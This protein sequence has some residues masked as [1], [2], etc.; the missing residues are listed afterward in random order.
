MRVALAIALLLV[1]VGTSAA[2][3]SSN[4]QSC[5]VAFEAAHRELKPFGLAEIQIQALDEGKVVAT[6]E[7]MKGRAPHVAMFTPD[8]DND[9]APTDW[10]Q[11]KLSARRQYAAGVGTI[12]YVLRRPTKRDQQSFDRFYAA[13]RKAIDRCARVGAVRGG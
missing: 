3:H 11:T 1:S 10:I 6:Y 9:R 4:T 5:L 7:W 2:Q 12:E 8:R 13:F